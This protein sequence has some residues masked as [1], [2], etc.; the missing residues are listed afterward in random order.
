MNPATEQQR[1]EQAF[2]Q[3]GRW[4]ITAFPPGWMYVPGFGIRQMPV[5]QGQVMANVGLGEDV[6]GGAPLAE[7]IGKQ[8]KMMEQ[9]LKDPK[10]AGPQG[11]GFAGAEEA[12]LLMVR[13]APGAG[14]SMLHVQIYIR[15]G[16]WI[17]IVTLTTAEAQVREVRPAY[18]YFVKGLRMKAGDAGGR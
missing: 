16:E 1:I 17:G 13:H 5:S 14:E 9:H 8:T 15:V 12:Q 6:T 11:T 7:Y 10:I 2:P 3:V 4:V 18:D